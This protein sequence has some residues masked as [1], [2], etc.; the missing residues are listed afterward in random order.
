MLHAWPIN[1]HVSALLVM[2][3][4]DVEQEQSYKR[5]MICM[6][7]YVYIYIYIYVC[8]CVCV[9]VYV[10][11]GRWGWGLAY[12]GYGDLVTMLVPSATQI[13]CKRVVHKKESHT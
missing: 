4:Y 5:C 11:V 8:V 7:V 12:R 3:K 6:Y 2:H 13:S 1:G 9:F 10:W